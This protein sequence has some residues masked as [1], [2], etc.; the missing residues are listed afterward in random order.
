MS[1]IID[2]PTQ[3]ILF[4]SYQVS[5]S[6]TY[7]N[8]TYDSSTSHL[9]YL[10]VNEDPIL[11]FFDYICAV[12]NGCEWEYMQ[13][14]IPKLI[15]LNYQPLY[16]LL[17]PKVFNFDGHPSLTQCYNNTVL[18]NCS[19]GS[20]RYYHSVDNNYQLEINRECSLFE[21]SSVEIGLVQYF[22]GPSKHDYSTLDFICDK[23]RCNDQSNVDEI[24][25]IIS[26]NANEYIYAHSLGIKLQWTSL[27]FYFLSFILIKKF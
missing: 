1:I 25:Q 12:G 9:A 22:P 3:E 16:D 27:I 13:Q 21:I 11:H 6:L 10:T 5:G 24:M 19:S 26:L 17:L 4:Y 7:D 23:D 14:I 15:H 2:Y 8:I 18:V 20:C